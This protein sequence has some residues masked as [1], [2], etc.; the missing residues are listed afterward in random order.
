MESKK[1]NKTKILKP[2]VYKVITLGDPSVGK[3]CLLG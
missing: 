2:E 1:I 3:T